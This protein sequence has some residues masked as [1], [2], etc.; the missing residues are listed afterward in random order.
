MSH[1]PFFQVVIT[2]FVCR[3][4]SCWS[5]FI[6]LPII[7][8]TCWLFMRGKV[9]LPSPVNRWRLV[10]QNNIF[11]FT[12]VFFPFLFSFTPLRPFQVRLVKGSFLLKS[13]R[14]DLISKRSL[15]MWMRAISE[16]IN[17]EPHLF[18]LILNSQLPLSRGLK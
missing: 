4:L 1:F 18:L 3:C 13:F 16:E 5:W 17:C 10:A 12:F 7:S 2:V 11:F 15:E 9:I 14:D 8:P 6:L